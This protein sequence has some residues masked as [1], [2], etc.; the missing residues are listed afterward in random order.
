V[1]DDIAFPDG[2][3]VTPHNATLIVAES[4]GN[5]LTTFD[6]APDGGLSNGVRKASATSPGRGSRRPAS[7]LLARRGVWPG[8]LAPRESMTCFTWTLASSDP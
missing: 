3:V 7:H 2:M 5:R 8:G 6:I 4:Y 1:A